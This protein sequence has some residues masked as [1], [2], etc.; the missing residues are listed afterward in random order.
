MSVDDSGIVKDVGRNP[1]PPHHEQTIKK[2]PETTVDCESRMVLPG[3]WDAHCHAYALGHTALKVTNLAGA[4]SVQELVERLKEGLIERPQVDFLE[5]AQWDHEELGRLPNSNDLDQV[6][7][8]TPI[9]CFRRCWHICV[10][11]SKT[12]ELCKIDEETAKTVEGIDLDPQTGKPTGILRENAM[13]LLRPVMDFEDSDEEKL[14]MMEFALQHFASNGI[15]SVQSNDT[16]SI[17]NISNAWKMYQKFLEKSGGELPCRVFYTTQWDQVKEDAPDS[18]KVME[19]YGKEVGYLHSDR[20][21]IFMDGA[22]GANTAALCEPYEDNSSNKG[23]INISD[24]DLEK[25]LFTAH[26]YKYRVEVHAIGDAAVEKIVNFLVKAKMENLLHQRPVITH[27]Q[28][29]KEDT[30]KKINQHF[31]IENSKDWLVANIQPQFTKSDLPIIQKKLGSTRAGYS[32]TWKRLQEF[33]ILAGGSDAPVEPAKPLQG[34]EEA[35]QNVLHESENLTFYKALAMYTTKAAAAAGI[36]V[37]NSLGKLEVGFQADFVLTYLKEPRDIL[38]NEDVEN[39]FRVQGTWIKG[40]K[41]IVP[42]TGIK[43]KK[44]E[45]FPGKSGRPMWRC[46]CHN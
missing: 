11:N 32:Y 20:C 22:L 25:A 29:M 21:K 16:K 36:G 46:S 13:E 39:K 14:E 38:G 34:M 6:S 9:I 5:G 30:L 27:F 33:C 1:L 10:V 35:M 8:E 7:S 17:G 41:V 4:N 3:L 43:A 28:M 12:L 45:N 23:L 19:G 15:T 44:L 31:P 40:R 24:E 18:D 26:K 42:V 37:E 2:S